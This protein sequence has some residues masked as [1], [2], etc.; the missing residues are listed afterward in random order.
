MGNY[1][2]KVEPRLDEIRKWIKDGATEKEIA[3]ALGVGYTSF[4]RYKRENPQLA[5]IMT[6]NKIVADETALGSF[7]RRVTGYDV[8]EQIKERDE[9]TGRMIVVKESVRHVAPDVQA[10]QF[11]LINR[12]PEQFKNKQSV[13]TNVTVERK[14]E[15]FAK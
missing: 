14:L 5:G 7:Y 12:M 8:V 10:G 6:A 15:D 11:W 4:R 2:K 13:D 3:Q 1:D 9:K